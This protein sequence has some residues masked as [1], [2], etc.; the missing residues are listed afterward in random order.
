MHEIHGPYPVKISIS[1]PKRAFPKAVQRNRLRR[2]VREAWRLNKYWL[3][4]KLG[5]EKQYAFMVIYIAKEPLE[6]G[7][8][9]ESVRRMN[10]RFLK[11][12]TGGRQ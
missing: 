9:E 6:I 5:T 3:Y 4:N 10:R 8:I 12:V 11:K 7:K 1:I 2:L